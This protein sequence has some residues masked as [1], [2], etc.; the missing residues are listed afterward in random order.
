[1]TYLFSTL[2]DPPFC[3]VDTPPAPSHAPLLTQTHT[4]SPLPHPLGS[5]TLSATYLSSPNFELDEL[6]S[7]LSSRFISL[8]LQGFVPTLSKHAVREE[9]EDGTSG[10]VG[11]GARSPPRAIVGATEGGRGGQGRGLGLGLGTGLGLPSGGSAAGFGESTSSISSM[12]R[13]VA[14]GTNTTTDHASVAERFIIP[15]RV[16]SLGPSSSSSSALIPPPRPQFTPFPL[17]LPFPTAGAT[18]PSSDPSSVVSGLALHRTRMESLNSP[19]ITSPGPGL[20]VAGGERSPSSEFFSSSISPHRTTQSPHPHAY[21]YQS[22][23]LSSSPISGAGVGAVP[24]R[25]GM[26]IN[27]FKANTL[28]SASASAS[29]SSPSLSIRQGLSS[30]LASAGIGHGATP[31]SLGDRKGGL[32]ERDYRGRISSESERG[33]WDR[34]DSRERDRHRRVSSG[35]N[36]APGSGSPTI[37]NVERQED[38]TGG[39]GVPTRIQPTRKRY[40]SSFGNRYVGSVGSGGSG[41]GSGGGE[42]GGSTPASVGGGTGAATEGREQSATGVSFSRF[43][44]LLPSFYLA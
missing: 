36:M 14:S 37:P 27:P 10:V 4:F 33:E 3:N 28:S 1:M 7:H 31:S 30:G 12:G 17:P 44:L 43:P 9:R 5:L 21:P 32:V 42:S 8:D 22:S 34:D 25:G 13:P 23:S 24:I 15:S 41:V 29:G 11:P 16:P 2:I 19:S 39:V 40:S 18:S 35:Y 6:E 38:G 26:G 20:G